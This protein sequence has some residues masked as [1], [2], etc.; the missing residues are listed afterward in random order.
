[1]TQDKIQHIRIDLKLIA[2]LIPEN[3]SVLDLGCGT[4]ELLKQLITEKKVQGHGVELYHEYI[5]ECIN[6][7][8]PVVHADL[9][10][11]L[12]DYPDKSFDYVILSR[13][14]QVV[15]HPHLVIKEMLRVGKTCIIS[16]PNFGYW[17][18]RSQLFF[19]GVMPGSK[20][21]PYEWYDTPNIHLSTLKDFV[22]FCREENIS[23]VKQINMLKEKQ[24]G[25]LCCLNTNLFSDLAIFVIKNK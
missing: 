16:L 17:R 2:D 4:G 10:E 13:T 8:V 18:L 6:N 19:K 22:N 25:A 24:A 9:N 7:G 12:S 21:L 1:M 20:L 5:Y 14:L 23:I 15:Y 11:G 3:S